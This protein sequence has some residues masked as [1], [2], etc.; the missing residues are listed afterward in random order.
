MRYLGG[1]LGNTSEQP[2]I[3]CLRLNKAFSS[4][5][6]GSTNVCGKTAGSP[7]AL[8]VER[9][10]P[11]DIPADE[12]VPRRAG[13]NTCTAMA[14]PLGMTPKPSGATMCARRAS[15]A[16]KGARMSVMRTYMAAGAAR[17]M[18]WRSATFLTW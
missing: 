10:D 3:I 8:P 12:R 11:D 13:S 2:P 17:Y 1:S 9:A 7:V 6:C 16:S 4:V 18:R 15:S 5:D 14:S